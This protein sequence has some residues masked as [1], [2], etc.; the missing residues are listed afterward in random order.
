MNWSKKNIHI[1]A[2]IKPLVES[3]PSREFSAL[4]AVMLRSTKL[5]PDAKDRDLA[6]REL[7]LMV[8]KMTQ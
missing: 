8:E 7:D 3:V 5:N 1:P 2:N 6:R 4:V